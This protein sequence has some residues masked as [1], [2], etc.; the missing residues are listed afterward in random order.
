MNARVFGFASLRAGKLRLNDVRIEFA[1]VIAL[2]LPDA[3]PAR[4]RE[5]E[6]AD[7]LE[8]RHL[9]VALDRLM[10]LLRARRHPQRALRLHAS[11]R[12]LA[13]DIGRARKIFVRRVRAA[14]DQRGRELR[15]IGVLRDVGAHLRDR[16]REIRRVR[17]D[18]VRLELR[19]ID[20]DDLVVELLRAALDLG[21]RREQ[22]GVLRR[23]IRELLAARR[24]EI[25]R[26]ALVV[27]EDRGGRAELGAHVRDRALAGARERLR[28]GAEILDHAVRA[29]LH[30]EQRAHFEDHVLRRAPAGEAAG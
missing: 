11:R 1:H 16:A 30:R 19:Q 26:H 10:D 28:A 18:D 6:R 21:I 22:L 8:L 12:R 20:L 2:P 9:A 23:E 13:R 3:R 24:L 4:V 14:A 29:A 15:R 17:A 25:D 5:H 27:R 7:R